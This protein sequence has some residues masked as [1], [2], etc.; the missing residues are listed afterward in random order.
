MWLWPGQ[1]LFGSICRSNAKIKNGLEYVVQAVDDHRVVVELS[2]EHRRQA[3]QYVTSAMR[4]HFEPH[5]EAVTH[6]LDGGPRT[7]VRLAK[8]PALQDLNREL[9]QRVPLFDVTA[10]WMLLADLFPGALR[11]LGVNKLALPGEEAEDEDE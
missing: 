5:V 6:A 2:P 7:V 10:R 11:A 9:K 4:Q 8:S 3:E 1:R